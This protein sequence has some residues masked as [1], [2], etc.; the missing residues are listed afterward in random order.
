M[1]AGTL[2]GTIALELYNRKQVQDYL[3]RTEVIEVQIW[4]HRTSHVMFVIYSPLMV[5]VLHFCGEV[6]QNL[7]SPRVCKQCK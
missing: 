4:A 5:V 6:I 3:Y 7:A 2:V 1:A